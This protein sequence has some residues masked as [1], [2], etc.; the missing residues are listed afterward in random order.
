MSGF[1]DFKTGLNDEVLTKFNNYSKGH[2][3]SQRKFEDAQKQVGAHREHTFLNCIDYFR[4]SCGF[5]V[6]EERVQLFLVFCIF[7]NAIMM[8][9]GTFGFVSSDKSIQSFFDRVDLGFLILFSIELGLQLIFLGFQFFMDGWMIFDFIVILMSWSL[10]SIQ[11]V[12]AFRI[13][14]ALRLATRVSLM[15]NLVAAV[16]SVMPRMGAIALLLMLIFYI[17]AVMMTQMFKNLYEDGVTDEDYFSRLDRTLFTLFQMMTLDDWA[18][19][20]RQV[21]DYYFWAWIPILAFV[22]ISGFIIVNLIVA[23]MCEA[24][25]S[26]QEDV[27]AKIHGKYEEGGS[28]ATHDLKIQEYLEA[29]EDQVDELTRLQ[30]Q[31]LQTL[32]ELTQQL[33]NIEGN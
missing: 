30:D 32:K 26:L 7:I 3:K 18:G 31:M 33:K 13:F 24:V 25:S 5:V 10:S 17:F 11:V 28:H 8:G 23:V 4:R 27:K 16:L 14:R 22:T 15:K 9:V 29:L 2:A 6:N 12:R 21:I 20:A 19:I 1:L